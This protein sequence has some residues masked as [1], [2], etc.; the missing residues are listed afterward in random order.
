MVGET[1][2][3]GASSSRTEARYLLRLPDAVSFSTPLA[4]RSPMARR[5]VDETPPTEGRRESVDLSAA[6]GVGTCC[7]QLAR[8]RAAQSSPAQLVRR[9]E[10]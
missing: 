1:L 8:P 3:G 4:C 9:A 7:V 2:L 6:G 10:R 5:C